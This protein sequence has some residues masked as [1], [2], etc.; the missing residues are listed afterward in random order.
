MTPKKI[1]FSISLLIA[2]GIPAGEAHADC[3]VLSLHHG[4]AQVTITGARPFKKDFWLAD[5]KVE[6]SLDAHLTESGGK[7]VTTFLARPF[8][9]GSYRKVPIRCDHGVC[10]LL[11]S[12]DFNKHQVKAQVQL[13]VDCFDA[14]DEHGNPAGIW[15]A[16]ISA[17]ILTPSKKQYQNV[18]SVGPRS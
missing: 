9:K 12:V 18:M 14:T 5:L 10:A 2:L 4:V 8:F 1:S 11:K 6:R 17:S 16:V 3:A 7:S 15:G 13:S